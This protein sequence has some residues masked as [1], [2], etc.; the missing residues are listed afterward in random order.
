MTPIISRTAR[1][2]ALPFVLALSALPARAGDASKPLP[3]DQAIATCVAYKEK[4]VA[5]KEELAD[6]FAG[7]APADQRPRFR[8]KAL[9]EIVAEGTGPL[10]PRQDKCAKDVEK[11][12]LTEADR[13]AMETCSAVKDCHAA[14]ECAKSRGLFRR[15]SSKR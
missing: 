10:A 6:F 5:C 9:Q 7:F 14:I 2:A 1:N 12:P 13:A 15:W 3:R 8:E 11:S 4:A